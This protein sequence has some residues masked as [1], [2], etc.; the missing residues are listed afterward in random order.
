METREVGLMKKNTENVIIFVQLTVPDK[1]NGASF[2]CLFIY[3]HHSLKFI[4]YCIF[5]KII[6]CKIKYRFE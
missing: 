6:S 4:A 2:V 1:Y 5:K 3:R